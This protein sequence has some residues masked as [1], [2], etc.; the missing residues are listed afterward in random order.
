MET[1][2]GALR[3]RLWLDVQPPH[4]AGQRRLRLRLPR[5]Q[6]RRA[7]QRAGDLLTSPLTE[8]PGRTS[9]ANRRT[10]L[11]A[12][13]VATLSLPSL[14]AAWPDRPLSIIVP[15]P[16]GGTSD[17]IARLISAPLGEALKTIVVVEN[18][19]GAN[20]AVGAAAVAQSSNEHMILLS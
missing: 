3:A 14:A 16:P 20:G 5:D 9:M 19:I 6:L 17:V 8:P 10:I 2:H 11:K 12:A 4:P 13:A 1:A 15:F 7:G 18:K